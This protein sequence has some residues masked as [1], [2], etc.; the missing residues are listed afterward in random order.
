[1]SDNQTTVFEGINA[2][3]YETVNEE[4]QTTDEQAGLLKPYNEL[5][6]TYVQ[7]MI[8][9]YI[10]TMLQADSLE[11]LLNWIPLVF[12]AE[13][14]EAIKSAVEQ[15]PDVDTAR[16]EIVRIIVETWVSLANA[17][18]YNVITP[19]TLSA[20][21][22]VQLSKLFGE[23]SNEIV[24]TV[25]VGANKYEHSLTQ[26]FIFGLFSLLNGN[27]EYTFYIG[28]SVVTVE[29]IVSDYVCDDVAEQ[30]LY[31]ADLGIGRFAF[32]TPDVVRGVSTAAKWLNV[33]P[34]E[35]VKNLT[36]IVDGQRISLV[37]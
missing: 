33:D 10:D 6:Q 28:E 17:N 27:P 24:V 15:S 22:D 19:W 5:S 2:P 16:N 31:I 26:D 3:E 23:P 32:S 20:T 14:L 30:T 9:P 35:Y 1:M 18:A 36:G 12:E 8:K 21:K 4:Q 37:F 11:S 25:A 13:Y 34:N 7:F 29:D